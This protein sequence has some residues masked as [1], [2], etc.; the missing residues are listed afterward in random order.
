MQLYRDSFSEITFTPD[1]QLLYL[2][3][4]SEPDESELLGVYE[5]AISYAKSTKARTLVVDNSIGFTVTLSM[6]RSLAALAIPQLHLVEVRRFA[7]VTPP[8]V[9]Q[10]II[11]HKV[12]DQINELAKYPIEVAYF[13][14]AED[15]KAWA[16]LPLANEESL[17][18]DIG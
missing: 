13:G 15:A 8:D 16:S 2:R 9:F 3:W 4:Q 17:Q 10:E 14:S 6:Q 7:R 18:T 11:T 5:K 1:S 12:M